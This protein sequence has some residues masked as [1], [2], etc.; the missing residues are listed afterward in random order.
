MIYFTHVLSGHARSHLLFLPSE[1]RIQLWRYLPS[2][3]KVVYKD[4]NH[5][6]SLSADRSQM[7]LTYGFTYLD[8]LNQLWSRTTVKYINCVPAPGPGEFSAMFAA[9]AAALKLIPRIEIEGE[10]GNDDT[11]C[12]LQGIRYF[13]PLKELAI[14]TVWLWKRCGRGVGLRTTLTIVSYATTAMMRICCRLS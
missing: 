7:L 14:S 12:D 11:D 1:V 10:F 2:D 4:Y 13:A 5:D 6:K 9:S 8:T 3:S